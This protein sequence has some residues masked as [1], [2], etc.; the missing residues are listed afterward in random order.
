VLSGRFR[1]V[2]E[3]ADAT[4]VVAIASRTRPDICLMDVLLPGGGS[5]A[6]RLLATRLPQTAIVILTAS[7]SEEDFFDALRAGAVGY[8]LKDLD[9]G[10]LPHA[11]EGILAGE[12]AVPRRLV[13][14]LMEEFRGSSGRRVSLKRGRG[15][16]L[17]QREWEVVELLRDGLSTRRIAARLSLSPVTVRRHLSSVSAKLGVGDR[18]AALRLLR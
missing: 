6:A 4:E 17:T 13:P 16:S 7:S 5:R 10:R 12:S 15:P 1:V 11:L 8:L 9:P 2:G 18:E 3:A 14:R